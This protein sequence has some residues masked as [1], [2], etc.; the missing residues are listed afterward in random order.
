M[1]IWFT[2]VWRS[3]WAHEC[4]VALVEPQSLAKHIIILRSVALSRVWPPVPHFPVNANKSLERGCSL[5]DARMGFS[6]PEA[7]GHCARFVL[8]RTA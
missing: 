4:G 2:H 6:P 8:M 3:M 5:D 7:K 1:C